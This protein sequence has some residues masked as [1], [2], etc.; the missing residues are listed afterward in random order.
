MNGPANAYNYCDPKWPIVR[1]FGGF[2][3]KLLL[4][5]IKK[6][7]FGVVIVLALRR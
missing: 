4:C 5:D 2:E 7:I 1:L 6:K 3:K